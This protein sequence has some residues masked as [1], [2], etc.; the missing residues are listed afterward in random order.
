M[1]DIVDLA[2]QIEAEH[3][4]RALTRISAAIPAGTAGIC[5]ECDEPRE[6]LVGGRCGFCRDGRTPLLRET[7]IQD[8]G[9]G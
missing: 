5:D 3:L 4:A 9:H 2:N 7:A 6:R 1:T 8:A